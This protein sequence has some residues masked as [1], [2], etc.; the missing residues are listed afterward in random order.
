MESREAFDTQGIVLRTHTVRESDRILSVLT[1]EAGKL[2]VIAR[3]ALRSKRRFM[4]GV[5]ILDCGKMHIK[6]PTRKGNL[7]SLE[8][9]TQRC[10]WPELRESIIKCSLACWSLEIADQITPEDDCEGSQL[11]G[12]LTQTLNQLNLSSSTAECFSL[13]IHFVT[14]TLGLSG[15]DPLAHSSFSNSIAAAWWKSMREQGAVLPP[16]SEETI[17]ESILLL[18]EYWENELGHQ[19]KTKSELL[20]LLRQW[21]HEKSKSREWQEKPLLA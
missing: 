11:Y 12:P 9:L 16:P 8:Q 15:F 21:A 19:F 7:P 2:S 5:D 10:Y 6:S 13:A 17:E 1:R 18:V 20:R 4:S 3:G 14:T